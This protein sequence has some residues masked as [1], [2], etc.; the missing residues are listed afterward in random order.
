MHLENFAG[1]DLISHLETNIFPIQNLKELSTS[2]QLYKIR[3]LMQGQDEYDQNVQIIINQLSRKL[4]SPVTVTLRDNIPY[5]ALPE[6]T[7]LPLSP[8]QLVRTTAY[9]EP[10]NEILKLDYENPTPETEPI[11]VRILQ[12]VIGGMLFNNPHFWQPAPGHAFFERIPIAERDGICIYRGYLLRVLPIDQGKFGICLDVAYKYVAYDPIPAQIS[13]EDFRSYKGIKCVYKFGNSWYEIQLHDHAGLN[14]KEQMLR[15]RAGI[16]TSLYEYII[17]HTLKPLPKEIV[18]LSPNTSALQYM[19]YQGEVRHAAASLCF[20]VYGTSDPRIQR[21]H[22]ETILPPHKR[23]QLIRSFVQSYLQIIKAD[24]M[25]IKVS[26][27]PLSVPNTIFLPPDLMFGNDMILSVRAS[28]GT[29]HISPSKMGQARL[30]ALYDPSIGPYMQKP[31]DNQYLIIPQTVFDS[32]GPAVISDLKREVNR[33]YPQ[34]IPYD[35]AIITY[36]DRVQ[37]TFSAQ[38]HAILKA[39]E[40]ASLDPGFGIAMIH[41][42]KNHRLYQRDQLAAMLMHKLRQKG[43]YISIIHSSMANDSYWLNPDASGGPIYQPVKTRLGR[44]RGYLRNVAINKVLLLNERWPFV[45]HTPLNADLTIAID[46]QFH[47]A[48]FT[49]MGKSGPD[50][51]TKPIPSNQKEKLSK[52]HV[53]RVVFETLKQEI[54]E[55]GRRDINTIV[56]QRDGRLFDSEIRGIKEAIAALVRDGLL[57]ATVSLNLIEIH[58]K[59]AV[60]L[61]LFDVDLRSDG[62]RSIENPQVGAH[63]LLNKREGYICTTGREFRHFGTAKPLHVRYIE[64]N[65]PFKEVLADVYSQSCLA[66]TRPEDCSRLPFTLKLTDIRLTEHAGEYDEDELMFPEDEESEELELSILS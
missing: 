55:L 57:P 18:N 42:I 52:A 54:C 62:N 34:E 50:I 48:C 66:L 3:G 28:Q 64:G 22:R 15:D 33:L 17:N 26:T 27:A 7:P 60:P 14:I 46:V 31:L 11:C 37:R 35:P 32:C 23:N 12:F 36:N 58:K 43:I 47:T 30:S 5:L 2:Y 25:V 40:S 9:F 16:N 19:T 59:S 38:G 10:T 20:R 8:Y 61:R 41:D 51:R 1:G 39:V 4:R 24:N 21:M 29:M 63:I 49:F 13:R 53:K 45:L 6:K 56:I 44:L 65:L